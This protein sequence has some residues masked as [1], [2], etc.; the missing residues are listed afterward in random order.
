LINSYL[1]LSPFYS[2]K[3]LFSIENCREII[4]KRRVVCYIY[5]E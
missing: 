3:Y 4:T 5:R 2:I 1:N